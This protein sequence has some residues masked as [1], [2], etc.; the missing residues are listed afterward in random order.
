MPTS[1]APDLFAQHLGTPPVWSLVVTLFGDLSP[2]ENTKIAG[3][4]LSQF[5]QSLG[6]KPE[7]LRVALHR[8]KQDGWVSAQKRGRTAQ[9]MLTPQGR[10]ET[11]RVY[12]LIYDPVTDLPQDWQIAMTKSAKGKDK[13]HKAGFRQ[14]APRIYVAHSGSTAPKGTALFSCTERPDWLSELCLSEKSAQAYQDLLTTFKELK[15]QLDHL[16]HTTFQIAAL[17]ILIVH[18]WRR[19]VLHH[20]YLPPSL[21]GADWAGHHCR[22]FVLEWLGS[23]ARPELRELA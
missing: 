22:A 13:L 9:Y 10:A 7:A 17:R 14:I 15:P 23:L 4:T 19:L 11:E 20:P 1:R 6:I 18:H 3:P 12:P 5:A 21:T 16:A 2:A 8:L